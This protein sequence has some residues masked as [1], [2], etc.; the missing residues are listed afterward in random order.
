MS[1][2]L[3]ALCLCLL[4]MA[5]A[6]QD[7][8]ERDRDFLTAFLE[9]NLS[10]AGRTIRIDG[11]A[12]AL[13][14]R[15]TFDEMSIADDEGVWLRIR[16]GAI[17]WNRGAL[18]SGRVEISE[19]SAAEIDLPRRPVAEGPSAEASGFALPDLPVSISIGELRA[20]RVRLGEALFGTAAE[21]S[22]IGQAELAEGEGSAKLDVQRIDGPEGTISLAGSYA[23]AT[24]EATLDLLV[25]EG[26]NGIAVSMLGLPGAPSIELAIHGT[27][28]IDNFATD[29]SLSTDGTPRLTGKVTLLTTDAEGGGQERSFEA[30]LGGDIAPLL[31]PE[32]REFF[33]SDVRLEADGLRLASGQTDLTRLVV[34]S[35]GLD[36]SGRLSIAPDGIPLAAALT[37]RLGSGDGNDVLLPLAGDK[38]YVRAADLSLRYNAAR[39]DA[40]T[41]A[42]DLYGLRQTGL[43][44]G[45][46]SLAG[47]GRISRP[48]QTGVDAARVGGHVRFAAAGVELADDAVATAVGPDL[49]GRAV[50]HWLDG[51]PL[52]I[53]VFEVSGQ[54]YGAEGGFRI[55]VAED[56]VN[57]SGRVAAEVADLGRF[58]ALAGRPLGGAAEMRLS[59]AAGLLSGIFDLE[60]RIEG[61]DLSAGQAELDRL[62]QG[63]ASVNA[64]VNRDTEGLTIRNF[65]IAARTLRATGSGKLATGASDIEARLEF[66]DL[67][68][69]GPNYQGAMNAEARLAETGELRVVTLDAGAQGLGI[70]DATVDRL[71]SGPAKLEVEVED[72]GGEV[73]LR[74]LDLTNPQL[75][76]SATGQIEDSTRYIDLAAR[77]ND[78]AL[79]APGFPG[80]LSAEG[81][82]TE[83][84]EGYQLDIAASGPGATSAT[85]VGGLSPDFSSADLSITG[86]AQSAIINPFIRPRNVSGPVSFDLALQGPIGLPALSG[87][88]RLADARVVAPT[89]GIEL[90]AVNIAADLGES[91]AMLSGG[92]SVRGGGRIDLSGPVAL[93][94]PFVGDLSMQLADVTLRDPELYETSVDGAVS[95]RGPLRG[96]ALI[97]GAVTLGRT[98]IRIPSSGFGG[99]PVLDGLR[100]VNEPADVRTT[101]RRA[102]FDA[103]SQEKRDRG[104]PFDIDLSVTAPGRIFVRGRGLDAE[105]DG[106]LRLTGTTAAIVPAGQFN[107]VRGRLDI[108]GKRFTIDEG[109]AE[110]QG[111]LTP[112]VRFVATTEN[113]GITAQIVIEGEA[114]EPEI[115]FLSSPELPEEEVIAHLL[116]GRDL[117]SLSAFQAAQLAS[118][119]ATLAGKGGE[120]IVSKLR[121][122]FG[123]DDFDVTTGEDGS[124]AVR[125][126]KYLTEKVYTDVVI[127]SDGKSEINLNLD[128]RPGVTLK[129]ALGSDGA[130]GIG[131]YYERD[132]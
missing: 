32:Y 98:E 91:R 132:Y 117:S 111:A 59:G 86:G 5:G 39:G 42:G 110:L 77:L 124:A 122:S 56:G 8:S 125:A 119:V 90:E 79:L 72:R 66:S 61:R 12:G 15:A 10:G 89:F 11:F 94:A 18:L 123:L 130:T 13:S 71:L 52:S 112:Y 37:A 107:L 38:T 81:R 9:D 82:V 41:L 4:P 16:D 120:G 2:Y 24:R 78:M 126:G 96:G 34:E 68:V 19:M 114:S 46:I 60:A 63:V 97:S 48:G 30:Q 88:I 104:V 92:A 65:A 129:G 93:T 7:T 50:F 58:S 35:E 40:W 31:L 47:S 27:G 3:F 103:A 14:S 101:L 85:I 106:A 127:G 99:R 45:S 49:N 67:S 6:A 22:L 102:G 44:L 84:G 73:R 21:I 121:N 118:A 80:P 51:Q 53:S 128:V 17:S 83:T 100:H 54:G 113:A 116:F 70:G 74:K 76:L 69:L 131:I 57:V 36:V 75:S 28:V 87:Q 1:R 109:R 23:N 95:V 20:D 26:E 55:A 62:L 108:L 25:A 115:R 105:M 33:G 29:I 64:S 43:S